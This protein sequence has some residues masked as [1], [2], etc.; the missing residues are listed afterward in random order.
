M[1]QVHR[2]AGACYTRPNT[3][4]AKWKG[5]IVHVTPHNAPHPLKNQISKTLRLVSVKWHAL[6][7]LQL[8]KILLAF[9]V[10]LVA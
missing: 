5:Q 2:L 7:T 4:S 6:Q 8:V 10:V 3:M 1:F 9:E